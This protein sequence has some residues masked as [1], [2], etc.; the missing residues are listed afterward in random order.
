MSEWRV[1]CYYRAIQQNFQYH[2]INSKI[3]ARINVIIND[4]NLSLFLCRPRRRQLVEKTVAVRKGPT[5]T[6]DSAKL[7]LRIYP[8]NMQYKKN[9]HQQGSLSNWRSKFS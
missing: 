8:S 4:D 9:F 3:V 6:P 1:F 2:T 5:G 7:H